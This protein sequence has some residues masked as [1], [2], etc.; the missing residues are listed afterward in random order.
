MNKKNM[1]SIDPDADE[2]PFAKAD[3]FQNKEI[4]ISYNDKIPLGA[5]QDSAKSKLPEEEKK[6][7]NAGRVSSI[8]KGSYAFDDPASPRKL[9]KE[10]PN[11]AANDNSPSQ[12]PM[13]SKVTIQNTCSDEE[14]MKTINV[15]NDDKQATARAS[16]SVDTKAS[17][18]QH[19]PESNLHEFSYEG[20]KFFVRLN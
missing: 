11:A 16:A 6:E 4:V 1:E 7:P 3:D 8:K 5:K 13:A 15:D 20:R 19:R 17:I 10:A 12:P 9:I 2:D 18:D 14:E